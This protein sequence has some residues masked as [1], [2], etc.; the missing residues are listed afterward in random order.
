MAVCLLHSYIFPDHELQIASI[1]KDMGFKQVCLSS[2][3]S[4]RPKIV[5]RGNS[6]VVDAYLTPVINNYLAQF[7]ASF[8]DMEKSGVRLDFMQSDGGLVPSSSLSG[9]KSILSGPAGGVVGYAKTSYSSRQG[10]PLIGF[11]MGGTSTDVSRYSGALEHTF[12]S[13][14]AGIVVQ[15]PQ[16]DISTIAAG[17]GSILTWTDGLMCVGPQSASSQPGPACYRKGGPLTITDANLALG[18]L[19]P[20]KFP[21][22]FGP[23]E[24]Q[25]LDSD[26]VE[27]K[28]KELAADINQETHQSLTWRE[29]AAGFVDVANNSMCEPI[30]SLT[31]ARGHDADAHNLASFGG[32]GGQHA[33]EIA[34]ILGIRRVLIHKYSSILSAYGIGLA[35][36]VEDRQEPYLRKYEASI[37][38]SLEYDLGRLEDK[39]RQAL[40]DEG[41]LGS[42][43]L[44]RYLSLRYD[45]SDTS[46]MVAIEPDK[47][48]LQSFIDV[49]L[50]EFGFSLVGRDIFVDEIR[51]RAVG[52]SDNEPEGSWADE[53]ALLKSRHPPTKPS[54]WR[55]V[56]FPAVGQIKTPVYDLGLLSAGTQVEGPC[57]IVD[58]T[59]TLLV[60]SKSTATI[61][62]AMVVLDVATA[63]KPKP[64]PGTIDPIRLS[65]FRHRFFGVAEK[66]GR[67]LQ[68]VSV[69]AN[70]KERLDFS[71]AIFTPEGDL[72]ANAPHVPAMIGSMAFAVKSQIH[73]WRG[74]LR[75]GDVLLSN[76]PE[77][78]GVHLP[79]MTVITPVFDGD[80]IVFWAASRG[81]H[82]DVSRFQ[83]QR[84]VRL[85]I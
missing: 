79:D 77:Y 70:I 1:A 71:C 11:D 21:A 10:V 51:V 53:L 32:A 25:L 62:S 59:Q 63:E 49:H 39:T 13:N 47:D 3:V 55:D 44:T 24:D 52:A 75:S 14:T 20:E 54:T 6:T 68:K 57:L 61:L 26:I 58:N 17:G 82:A 5:P 7:S 35:D 4:A 83:S 80:E 40:I 19:I 37:W 30:R 36:L 9:L 31:E 84:D 38:T 73:E 16:L 76:S 33:C 81:H 8:P 72:V 78:G 12:E 42:I 23:N 65:V 29:V 45:G 85:T 48:P 50:H 64:E 74:K 66:M 22:V 41:F 46:L 34:Q 28:F 18:R 60:G 67:T 2:T 69:S 27:V 15:V 56:Y 43:S